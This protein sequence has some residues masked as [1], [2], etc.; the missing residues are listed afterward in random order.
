MSFLDTALD[1]ARR[2]LHVFPLKPRDKWP[3]VAGGFKAATLDQDQIRLWWTKTPNA[4]I[5][6]ACEASGLAVV[7]ND[8]GLR[9]YD[10]F[11]SWRDRNGLPPTY[12]VRSGRRIGADGQP[13]YGVQMYYSDPFSTQGRKNWKL[14]GCTGDFKSIGGLVVAAGS[15]HVDSGEVYEVLCDL[16]IVRRP[17]FLLALPTAEG[18]DK[19]TGQ[20]ND[21]GL[22][23]GNRNDEMCSFVG[24]IRKQIAQL[25]EAACLDICCHRNEQYA[26]GP[27]PDDELKEI[28]TKQYRLYPDVGPDPVAFIGSKPEEK[29]VT[30]WREHYHTVKDHDNVGPP[31]YLVESFLPEQ[32][33]MGIGAL[34]GQKKTLAALN[35]VFSLC[36]GE[37]LFGK[38]QVTRKPA[39]VLYLGP[40]NGLISF[41]DRVNRIGLRDY[42][43]K[44]FF[45]ATM[46]ISESA[47]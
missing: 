29:K 32:A 44:S 31:R 13:E 28:V 27:L 19:S 1:L 21:A 26:K 2:G 12:T 37:P 43:C 20:A 15:I 16:P 10:D 23:E 38:Y 17:E 39:R 7:D 40:E 47:R 25:N 36:S 45:Y 9:D 33:I 4:N 18:K 3:I 30:D 24:K 22:I 46:S 8:H 35:I 5:G 34:V 41:S 6:I 11:I 14:D 42:L